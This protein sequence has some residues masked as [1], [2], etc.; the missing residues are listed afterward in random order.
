M[1][2]DPSFTEHH[3]SR[4]FFKRLD[5]ER[6]AQGRAGLGRGLVT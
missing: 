4:V 3:S 2:P 1:E 5:P 6:R